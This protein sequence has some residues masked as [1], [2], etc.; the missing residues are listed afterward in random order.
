M[1]ITITSPTPFSIHAA[2][3]WA[4]REAYEKH[5]DEF[6]EAI[7]TSDPLTFDYEAAYEPLVTAMQKTAEAAAAVPATTAVELHAKIETIL[8]ES[9]HEMGCKAVRELFEAIARDGA[10]I[11]GVS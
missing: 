6:H 9:L 5:R 10:R 3:Y 1:S 7:E 2:A 11:G 8:N 4:A